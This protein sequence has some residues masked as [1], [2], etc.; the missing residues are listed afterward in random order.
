MSTILSHSPYLLLWGDVV[1]CSDASGQAGKRPT[2]TNR[3]IRWEGGPT[4][5]PPPP[6][7]GPDRN[8]WIGKRACPP[9]PRSGRDL[10][11]RWAGGIGMRGEAVVGLPHIVML[12]A[13]CFV[14]MVI[15]HA[16]YKKQIIFQ[17]YVKIRSFRGHDTRRT[18]THARV[19]IHKHTRT[20]TPY[21]VEVVEFALSLTLV[22]ALVSG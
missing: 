9:W 22:H 13:G 20:H 5:T 1:T 19:Q 8:N 3:K 4:L 21:L 12:I 18:H 17:G 14:V 2:F 10:P 6:R 11:N 7:E 16:K 15:N